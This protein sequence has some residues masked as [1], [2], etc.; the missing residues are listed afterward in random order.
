MT[1]WL[2]AFLPL[3]KQTHSKNNSNLHPIYCGQGCS[4]DSCV[5]QLSA[6]SPTRATVHE[7]TSMK[8]LSLQVR[9]R[10]KAKTDLP[11]VRSLYQCAS[12]DRCESGGE[13]I[14]ARRCWPCSFHTSFNV[15]FDT[16]IIC[17]DPCK[18]CFLQ[19]QTGEDSS[20]HSSPFLASVCQGEW[21]E[22]ASAMGGIGLG[23][24]HAQG[25]PS[26]Q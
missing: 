20:K 10:N 4:S 16:S 6:H 9:T 24:W 7:V 18:H 14:P 12:K 17:S 22:S 23:E 15:L 19:E 1:C 8:N 2:L 11:M 21:V 25:R 5:L 13:A 3:Q 26:Q